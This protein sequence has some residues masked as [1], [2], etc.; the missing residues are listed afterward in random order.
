MSFAIV[1]AMDRE[2]GIGRD[3]D[4][5]WHLPSDMKYFARLTRERDREQAPPNTVIMGRRTWESIPQRFRPLPGRSNLVLSRDPQY[6]VE[7]AQVLPTLEAALQACP[8]GSQV[9]VIGGSMIYE[10]ALQHPGCETL[11]ITELD[12]DCGC[13]CYFPEFEG[14]RLQQTGPWQ[15]ENQLRF[16]FNQWKKVPTE[17]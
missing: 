8:D 11:Y 6:Q 4:L 12:A 7:G 1:V 17:R 14:F 15:E 10:L 16:R 13:D 9:F 2:R 5:A 3:G